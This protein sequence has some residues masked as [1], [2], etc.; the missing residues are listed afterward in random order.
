[1]FE[2]CTNLTTAPE[3]PATNLDIYCYSG[4]FEGCTN[5]TTA[6]ELPAAT[7][8][9]WCYYSMFQGCT[10]LNSIKCLA[11]SL[12]ASSCLATWVDNVSPSGT[13]YAKTGA[14]WP[15]NGTSSIPS[16]WTRVDV[17]SK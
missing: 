12:S 11:T 13:F 7:L 15:S 9:R 1:M 2:G 3:L 14:T 16:G 10:D 4:M 8:T 17:E 5:L 6:P